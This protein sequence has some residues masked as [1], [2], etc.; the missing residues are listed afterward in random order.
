MNIKKLK[1]DFKLMAFL[2]FGGL[3]SAEASLVITPKSGWLGK[4]TV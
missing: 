3:N 2:L 4:A 1:V